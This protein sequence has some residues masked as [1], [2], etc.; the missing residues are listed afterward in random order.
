M[1]SLVVLPTI[2][3]NGYKHLHFSDTELEIKGLPSIPIT[4]QR[5][6]R[7]VSSWD[8][9]KLQIESLQLDSAPL[10]CTLTCLGNISVFFLGDLSLL[11][12]LLHFSFAFEL[13]QA[14]QSI[15]P[16]AL[17]EHQYLPY[18]SGALRNFHPFKTCSQS[19]F[20]LWDHVP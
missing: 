17:P 10:N 14:T 5:R 7:V 11:S 2:F 8:Q 3:G 15:W 4:F 20:C 6:Y 12:L 19:C 18:H 9:L 16:P 1:S 13:H